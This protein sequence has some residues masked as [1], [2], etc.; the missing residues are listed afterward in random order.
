MRP[1]LSMPRAS[2]KM[3]SNSHFNPTVR[4]TFVLV[5]TSTAK[6]W[7]FVDLAGL[8]AVD[9]GPSDSVPIDFT[10]FTFV[11]S[12]ATRDVRRERHSRKVHT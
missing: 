1:A 5:E 2:V 7:R 10:R 11:A 3:A 4:T 12:R 9:D 6:G 8:R